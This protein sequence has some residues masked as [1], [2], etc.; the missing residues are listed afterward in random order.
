MLI[1]AL[2]ALALQS[3]NVEPKREKSAPNDH[4]L[5]NGHA[6]PARENQFPGGLNH[7]SNLTGLANVSWQNIRWNILVANRTQEATDCQCS[8]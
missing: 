8:N 4:T 5:K 6:K 7:S 3:P 1:E 2:F